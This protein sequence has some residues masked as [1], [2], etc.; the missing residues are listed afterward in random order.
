MWIICE[1]KDESVALSRDVVV[2]DIRDLNERLGWSS[3][4]DEDWSRIRLC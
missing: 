1:L 4:V 3:Q 2:N